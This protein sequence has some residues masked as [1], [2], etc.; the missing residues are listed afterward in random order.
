DLFL[1]LNY[2]TDYLS[3]V[4]SEETGKGYKG[5]LGYFPTPFHVCILMTRMTKG[6]DEESN[7]RAAVNDPAVGCGAMLLA[8]SNYHLRGFGQDISKIAVE[9]C[10]IQM[11]WYAPWYAY[12]S[13]ELEGFDERELI[14]GLSEEKKSVQ[15]Q[16]VFSL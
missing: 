15:G 3:Q 2:P 4:L 1:I 13:S 9:L 16:L 6:E 12:H 5:A 11:Y 10:K 7:K 8:A 14:I